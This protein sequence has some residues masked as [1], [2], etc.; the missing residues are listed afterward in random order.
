MKTVNSEQLAV[1]SVKKAASMFLLFTAYC[2][3]LTV[4][5]FFNTI[6]FNE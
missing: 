4:Y 2:L 6:C 3:L 5:F 1:S